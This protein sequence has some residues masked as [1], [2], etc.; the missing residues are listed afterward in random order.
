[1]KY[2]LEDSILSSYSMS[3]GGGTPS[4]SMSISYSKITV[5]FAASGKDNAAGATPRVIYD[6]AKAQKG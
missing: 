5:S 2:E 3:G 4:E 6:L 1:M